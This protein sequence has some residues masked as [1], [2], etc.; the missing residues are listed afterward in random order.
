MAKKKQK[1]Y[2]VYYFTGDYF[3]SAGEVRHY[4]LI[5]ADNEREAEYVF[6]KMYP[7]YSFG[8]VERI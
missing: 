1:N 3:S 8:W 5:T 7:S 4:A 6:K 2:K